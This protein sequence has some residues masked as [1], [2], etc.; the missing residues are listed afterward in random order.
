MKLISS[1][2]AASYQGTT[3]VVPV[4]A[5][6]FPSEPASAGG[7]LIHSFDKYE[8]KEH[9]RATHEP[10]WPSRAL[11]RDRSAFRRIRWNSSARVGY[12]GSTIP[13]VPAPKDY[14]AWLE[15]A[16]DFPVAP[17]HERAG[18]GPPCLRFLWIWPIHQ[19][20]HSLEVA[21]NLDFAS[22]HTAALFVNDL[23][24]TV[25]VPDVYRAGFVSVGAR[26]LRLLRRCGAQCNRNGYDAQEGAANLHLRGTI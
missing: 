3:S 4:R 6:V 20:P 16:D 2:V 17:D 24:F 23:L 10:L 11:R 9:T 8:R 5:L 14:G 19:P 1:N 7:T 12:L 15:L 13:E 18:D 21:G 22:S 26:H 25:V